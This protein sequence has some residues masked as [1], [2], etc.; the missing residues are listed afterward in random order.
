[1][2]FILL[3]LLLDEISAVGDW[4]WLGASAVGSEVEENGCGDEM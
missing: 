1:M 4:F 3:G 2:R